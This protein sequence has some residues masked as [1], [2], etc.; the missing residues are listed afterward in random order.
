MQVETKRGECVVALFPGGSLAPLRS[1]R[2]GK[3][4]RY[5]RGVCPPYREGQARDSLWPAD[6][7]GLYRAASA[8]AVLRVSAPRSWRC[9]YGPIYRA[10]HAGSTVGAANLAAGARPDRIDR[11]RIEPKHSSTLSR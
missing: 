5:V 6:H 7:K 3:L 11:R 4:A 2:G 10:V 1:M 9:R 8:V